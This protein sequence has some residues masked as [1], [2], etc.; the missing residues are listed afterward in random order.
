MTVPTRYLHTHTG[1]IQ[2]SDF[3]QAVEL[4]IAVLTRLDAETVE[5]IG[6]FDPR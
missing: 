5:E 1:I 6:S 3:D 4:L 2:R